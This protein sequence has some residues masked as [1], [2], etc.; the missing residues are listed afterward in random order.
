MSVRLLLSLLLSLPSLAL[1]VDEAASRDAALPFRSTVELQQQRFTL[2]HLRPET[3]PPFPDLVEVE[4][5]VGAA[6]HVPRGERLE[7]SGEGL[8]VEGGRHRRDDSGSGGKENP[9]SWGRVGRWGG[10]AV[11]Q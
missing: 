9:A 2:T 6:Q 7:L 5:L 1:A 4:A 11:G 8:H 3:P 10:R